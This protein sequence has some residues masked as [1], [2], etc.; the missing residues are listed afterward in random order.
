MGTGT[1]G[2]GFGPRTPSLSGIAPRGK[3]S[4]Q[5]T[6][7]PRISPPS[8]SFV[9]SVLGLL[10]T[11]DNAELRILMGCP[12][13]RLIMEAIE[14]HFPRTPGVSNLAA[15]CKPYMKGGQAPGDVSRGRVLLQKFADLADAEGYKNLFFD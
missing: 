13:N 12:R 9:I 14:E 4:T 11:A 8:F 5:T 15:R 1:T 7:K 3:S 10:Y 2:T 6:Q